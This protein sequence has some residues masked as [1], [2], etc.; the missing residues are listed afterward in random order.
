VEQGGVSQ[1]SAL[2]QQ[3]APEDEL[4]I[5][6]R[7]DDEMSLSMLLLPQSGQQTF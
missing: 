1:R 5:L 2:P 7:Y 4:P 6:T 3:V